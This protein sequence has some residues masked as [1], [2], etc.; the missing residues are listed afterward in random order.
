MLRRNT[1]RFRSKTIVAELALSPIIA[2]IVLCH[3]HPVMNDARRAHHLT[4]DKWQ[5]CCFWQQL[6][7]KDGTDPV[8]S[9][10]LNQSAAGM[11]QFGKTVRAV[12]NSL[13][14][15]FLPQWINVLGLG[16]RTA[17]SPSLARPARS[18]ARALYALMSKRTTNRGCKKARKKIC[19]PLAGVAAR[20]ASR[21]LCNVLAGLCRPPLLLV[22][23]CGVGPLHCSDGTGDDH[24]GLSVATE[25]G[26]HR[27]RSAKGA[28]MS[29]G[30]LLSLAPRGVPIHQ[31]KFSGVIISS[32]SPSAT[33]PSRTDHPRSRVSCFY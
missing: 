28:R 15:V 19:A 26:L 5:L 29:Q 9:S 31:I 10:P 13:R 33:T 17:E 12:A 16:Q 8:G 14:L 2:F 3:F 30:S 32:T 6:R 1:Y 27:R 21:R 18:L 11:R 4:C 23:A 20:S 22:L 24:F 7:P 25:G